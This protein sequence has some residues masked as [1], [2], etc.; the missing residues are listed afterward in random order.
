M[1]DDFIFQLRAVLTTQIAMMSNLVN[2][3]DAT[4]SKP[5]QNAKDAIKVEA[6]PV[7]DTIKQDMQFSID[8]REYTVLQVGENRIMCEYFYDAVDAAGF[9]ATRRQ[10]VTINR[11]IVLQALTTPKEVVVGGAKFMDGDKAITIE[12]IK[13]GKVHGTAS[14]G[15]AYIEDVDVVK[16][17]LS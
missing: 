3:I 6:P 10:E 14:D 8:N 15:S 7:A 5:D 12:A 9:L 11:S 2:R 13:D 1:G 17:L 16:V 4:E